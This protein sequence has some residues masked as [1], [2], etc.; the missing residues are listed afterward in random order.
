MLVGLGLTGCLWLVGVR[1]EGHE[2]LVAAK[3]AGYDVWNLA[4]KPA[5]QVS[6][7]CR[8]RLQFHGVDHPGKDH[9]SAN[10]IRAKAVLAQ[11][12]STAEK[13]L[14]QMPKSESKAYA[15]IFLRQ[16]AERSL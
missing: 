14:R 6:A 7:E 12:Q 4:G 5:G 9:I 16:T 13:T 3:T 10:D 11:G 15:P 2:E 8:V 1:Q